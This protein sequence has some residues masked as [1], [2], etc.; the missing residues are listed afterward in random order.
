M[1]TFFS[2]VSIQTNSFSLEKVVVG[3]LAIT[4]KKVFFEYSKSKIQLLDKLAPHHNGISQFALKTLQQIK[5]KVVETNHLKEQQ[6]LL[7]SYDVF[8]ADYINYLSKYSNNILSFAKPE[9]L[10]INFTQKEFGQYYFNFVGE[11]LTL[12][13]KKQNISFAKKIKPYFEKEG[14]DEKANLK[15]HFN[16]HTFQG[17][18]KAADVSLITKNGAINAIQVIDF[19]LGE[20]TIVNHLY[21]TK[22]IHDAL[23]KFVKNVK[24]EVNK[25]KIAFEEPE[26]NTKQ[27]ELFDLSYKNYKDTFEFITPNALE[28]ETEKIANSNNIKFSEYLQTLEI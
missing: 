5:S 6:K 25:I 10:P 26:K 11:P 27:Y 22:I 13:T 12:N 24:G 15:Y 20:Q 8:T 3:V 16:P 7:A 19:S 2:L 4:E 9:A 1:K 21:E 17:I 28:K 23:H 18:L 14:L